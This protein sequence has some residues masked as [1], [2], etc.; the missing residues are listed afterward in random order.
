MTS[1]SGQTLRGLGSV[2]LLALLLLAPPLAL[3]TLVGWPL[4]T[5]IP[6]LDA[7]EMALRSGVSDSIIVR[8]LAL[9]GWAAWCQVTLAIAVEVVAV[10]RRR[11]S[12]HLPVLPGLQTFA[13][14]LV[15]SVVMMTATVS[16]AVATAASASPAPIPAVASPAPDAAAPSVQI[17]PST[18]APRP[19]GSPPSQPPSPRAPT[20]VTVERHD[21]Y[22][23]I[24]ER[25]LG[26]GYRWREV[27]DLN[28]GR[29]MNTGH[30][31]QPESELVLPGWELELPNGA[32]ARV[33]AEMVSES[34][35]TTSTEVVV[36]PGDNFWTLAEA[37]LETATGEQPT[38]VETLPYWHDMLEANENRL[39]NPGNP[40]LIVPGQHLAVPPVPG[41][42]PEGGT[43]ADRAPTLAAG[44]P[45]DPPSPTGEDGEPPSTPPTTTPTTAPAR[46]MPPP[47]AVPAPTSRSE[48]D[49]ASSGARAAAT[50]E[51]TEDTSGRTV[52]V[53]A[54]GIVSAALAVG[55]TRALR[56][57]RLRAAHRSPASPPLPLSDPARALHRELVADADAEGVDGLRKAL[58]SLA[59]ALADTDAVVRPRV[60]Q[61]GPDHLDVFLDGRHEAP[62]GWSTV[63]D[64]ALWTLDHPVDQCLENPICTTPLL[65][66]IGRPD[67]GGQLYLDLEAER[68]VSLVGDQEVIRAVSRA[69]LVELALTPLAE[70]LEVLVIGDVAP[71][72]VS[73]LG[74]V[75]L[76]ATWDEVADDL[77]AWAEQSHDAIAEKGWPNAFLARGVEPYHDALAPIVV[78]ADEPPPSRLLDQMRVHP[79]ATLTIVANGAVEDSTAIDCHPD[80]LTIVDL[81][82]ECTP[83]LMEPEILE[84]VI[85]LV[86]EPEQLPAPTTPEGHLP[87]GPPAPG[88]EPDP[89]GD[90]T[91]IA[92]PDYDIVVRVLGDIRVEGGDPLAAKQT[93]VVAYIALHATV[94]ADKLEDAVWA[95]PTT[96]SRRKRL[97][98]TI[99]ECRAALGRH[100]FPPASDGRYRAGPGIITDVELFDRRIRRAAGQC[101][102]EAVDTLVAALDLVTGPLFTYRATDRA[103]F[104]WVDVENWASTWE[105]NVAA[106]GQRCADLLVDVARCDEAADVARRILGIMPTHA[107]LT[108]SLMRAH[109]ANGDRLAV[110]RVYEE[111]VGA[112]LA[113]DLDEAADSTT[114]LVERLL[115]PGSA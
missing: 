56:R 104:A 113:L 51:A 20:T 77:C 112:L 6:N 111:H 2:A 85:D 114:E 94:S 37:Q 86:H 80:C 5:A 65:V 8:G 67:D 108:E 75:T 25:A 83:Y 44:A 79:M 103:S 61:H 4:P 98:N 87:Y 102:A 42:V 30:V 54:A 24:A 72:E 66:T 28:A 14:R 39:V 73:D 43:T 76:I 3:A 19:T 63:D 1:R 18:T 81:G 38:D 17:P 68:V 47:S 49:A 100:H 93:A 69:M 89:D 90:D 15:A 64:G 106:V 22:W 105:L 52:Q 57:R 71:T 88:I 107:G 109:F 13:G 58:G 9:I 101:P 7:V 31:V 50:V 48:P 84:A 55:A 92:E 59:R 10:V 115:E 41:A 97:A 35:S 11:P 95:S 99:S 26:D 45:V 53:I 21:S 27:R 32:N 16:P 110:R 46:S 23:A 29:T 91:A 33:L 96:T 34:P 12:G 36:E 82:L 60:V 62:P 78:I 40:S 74:H 70:T